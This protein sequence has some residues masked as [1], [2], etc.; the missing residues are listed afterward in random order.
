MMS[1]DSLHSNTIRAVAA[2]LLVCNAVSLCAIYL[3][4]R[5]YP[6]FWS[7]AGAWV[8]VCEP[9]AALLVYS[10]LVVWVSE[11]RGMWWQTVLRIAAVFGVAA[12][13]VDLAGLVVEDGLLFRVRGPAMQIAIM[14][15]LFTLWGAAGWRAARALNSMRAGPV[16]AVLSAGVCMMIAVAA[17]LIV[18]LFLVRP[19]VADVA[20]W[21]EFK[22]SGWTNPR[23][24]AI[25]NTLDSGFTHLMIAPIVAAITG[26]FGS[27]LSRYI[28]PLRREARL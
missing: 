19:S 20:T 12:A 18:Q 11:M 27:I 21:G 2:A 7:Q 3:G 4:V 22:R 13:A 15:T 16:A 6:P 5:Q 8:Y 17:A 14:L 10:G 26:S 1:A 24:F 23:A 28:Q 25:A 9:V